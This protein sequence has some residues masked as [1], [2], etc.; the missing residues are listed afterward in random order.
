MKSHHHRTSKVAGRIHYKAGEP[1]LLRTANTVGKALRLHC[2]I[3]R[4]LGIQIV[5]GQFQPGDL[6]GSEIASAELLAV[7]RTAYREA[8]RMLA[9][10][11]LVEARPKVGTRVNPRGAWHLLDPDV[12]DWIFATGPDL[13]LLDSL[14]ELRD[15]V[16]SAA[17]GF[18]A[19]RRTAA[20]LRAMHAALEGMATH[21]LGTEAGRQADL[22]FH[23]ALLLATDNPFVISLANGLRAAIRTA[24]IYKQRKQPP[25]HDPISEH[26][27]V[28]EAIVAKKSS[29]AQAAMRTL[30]ELAPVDTST[31]KASPKKS[32]PGAGFAKPTQDAI[33]ACTASSNSVIRQ[34]KA[35]PKPT[36]AMVE[37]ALTV[38]AAYRRRQQTRSD[39]RLALN[40]RG[41]ARLAAASSQT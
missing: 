35:V 6:L 10:K 5:S 13:M 40:A 11:G 19:T 21:T 14:F 38:E 26:I 4:K 31:M 37:I 23:K 27:C 3:A 15:I 24:T 30:V 17:A 1:T 36:R 29:K 7:S 33:I 39:R 32:A 8:V 20:H 41:R 22:D 12:L 25:G 16:E 2:S 9:A 18:A 34:S 28:F